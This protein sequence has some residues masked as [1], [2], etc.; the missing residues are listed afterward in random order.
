MDNP[1]P[2]REQIINGLVTKSNIKSTV[3]DTV[4]GRDKQ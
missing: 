1:L 4:L 2:A 3:F